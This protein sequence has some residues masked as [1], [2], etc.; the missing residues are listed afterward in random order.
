MEN[1]IDK[2]KCLVNNFRKLDKINSYDSDKE[3]ESDTLA[4]A[5]L[6]IAESSSLIVNELVPKLTANDISESQIEDI[7]HEIG[8]EFRHILYHIKDSKYYG[9]LDNS[10]D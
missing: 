5:I 1:Y 4:N 10:I 6:D 2:Y 9:Y 3:K 7:L 8:E